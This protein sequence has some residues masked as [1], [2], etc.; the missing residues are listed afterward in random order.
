MIR[1]PAARF[2]ED[3]KECLQR[4]PTRL[5]CRGGFPEELVPQA[6]SEGYLEV[7]TSR[8]VVG[9]GGSLFQPSGTA[10]K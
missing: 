6:A 7:R 10:H 1:M 9:Q 2:A 5:L 4:D 3:L 8:A